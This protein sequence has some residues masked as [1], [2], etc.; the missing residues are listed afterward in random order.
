MNGLMRALNGL[1]VVILITSGGA[2]KILPKDDNENLEQR[3]FELNPI[4]PEEYLDLAEELL[5]L[6][7]NEEMGQLGKDLLVRAV[8]WGYRRNEVSVASSACIALSDLAVDPIDRQWMWDLAYLIDPSR[9][10]EWVRARSMQD[11]L[12]VDRKAARCLF[13]I[14]YHQQPIGEELLRNEAVRD[15]ILRAGEE[16]G[17]DRDDLLNLLAREIQRGLDDACRG[18]LYIAERGNPGRRLACP[19]HLRGLGML[20]NDDD[21][22]VYLRVEMALGGIR[23]ESW[24]GAASM[25]KDET[26]NLPTVDALAER[27]G[28]KSEEAFYRDGRWV[29]SP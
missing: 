24:S 13:A 16:V 17:V 20:S 27:M 26:L 23:V 18:R 8:I 4:H 11:G 19:D 28:V 7:Q 2:G 10:N 9:E 21:L 3:L 5:V 15:R 12:S 14:R 1:L 29:R 22:R 25:S 6:H